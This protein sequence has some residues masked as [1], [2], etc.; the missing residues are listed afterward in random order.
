[1]NTTEFLLAAP[2]PA[3]RWFRLTPGRLLAMLLAIEAAL[4]LGDGLEWIPKGYAVLLAVAS[5][6]AFLLLVAVWFVLTLVF[7]L[8]FQYSL[9]SLL[10]LTIAVAIPCGW[11]AMEMNVARKQRALLDEMCHAGFDP[12]S[13]PV[14]DYDRRRLTFSEMYDTQPPSGLFAVVGGEQLSSARGGCGVCLETT[15]SSR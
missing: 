15:F 9:L 3:C 7:R 10:M 5:V 12:H 1:M 6:A 8:R 14:F 13:G 2:K 11:L 4:G